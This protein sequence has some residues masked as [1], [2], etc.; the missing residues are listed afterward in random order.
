[1]KFRNWRINRKITK[2]NNKVNAKF[3][4]LTTEWIDNNLDTIKIKYSKVSKSILVNGFTPNQTVNDEG[5]LQ[6][7]KC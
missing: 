3:E 1:M 6:D 4:K 2:I 5:Q 7:R